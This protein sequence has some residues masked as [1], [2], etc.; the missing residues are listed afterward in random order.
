MLANA[1]VFGFVFNPLTVYWCH[2]AGGALVCA[3]AEVH[4]T[5]GGRHRYLLRADHRGEVIVPKA[6]YVSPFNPVSGRYVLRVPEPTRGRL[7]VAITLLDASGAVVLTAT[8]TGSVHPARP[9]TVLT[10][11]LAAPLAPLL[12]LAR[13]RWQGVRLWARG[14]PL[15]PRPQEAA[16]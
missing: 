13:I 12:V 11:A 16:R 6:F 5:Y 8:W 1:R 15:H 9:T 7:C 2:D 10:T 4:N 3:I 14:L